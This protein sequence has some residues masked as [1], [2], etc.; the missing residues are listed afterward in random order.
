M[1]VALDR[2]LGMDSLRRY[3]CLLLMIGAG[4]FAGCGSTDR[5]EL[6]SVTGTVT[7]DGQPLPNVWVMFNPTTGGRTSIARTNEQGEYKMMYLEGTPGVNI[8]SHQVV[9]VTYNEDEVEEMRA[10]TGSPVKDPIPAKYNTQT[11][12]TAEVTDGKHVIDFPLSSG[13]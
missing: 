3:G 5:P 6:G 8:G 12:L 7:M 4:L 1:R 2:A 11:T 10:N 9:I 13:S